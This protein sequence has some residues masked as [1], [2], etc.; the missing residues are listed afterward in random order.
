MTVKRSRRQ[1]VAWLAVVLLAA[2]GHALAGGEARESDPAALEDA[3]RKAL[4][5]GLYSLAEGY[6]RD[7]LEA[8]K[9][10][11]EKG[12]G[13]LGLAEALYGE[14]RYDEVE[15][16]I[17]A[18]RGWAATARQKDG[19][20][21][22]KAAVECVSKN[23]KGALRLLK[24]LLGPA[25]R[26]PWRRRAI[27]LGARCHAALGESDAAAKMFAAFVEEYTD[28]PETGRALLAW[29]GVLR[30][31]GKAEKAEKILAD[32]LQRFPERVE[33]CRARLWLAEMLQG[34]GRTAEARKMLEELSGKHGAPA[35]LRARAWMELAGLD[36]AER[37]EAAL[38]AADE[39][40]KLAPA[41]EL[42]D[43][44]RIL[45]VKMAIENG[46]VTNGVGLLREWVGANPKN[47]RAAD[48]QLETARL[49]FKK[50]F[51]EA[52]L[53][54]FQHYL[55]MFSGKAGEGAAWLGRGWCLLRLGRYSEAAEA[56]GRAWETADETAVKKEALI[57]KGDALFA[58]GKY[59]EARAQY[60]AFTRD[61]PGSDLAPQAL[62]QAAECLARTGKSAAAEKELRAVA[63]AFGD[64]EIAERCWIR[65]AELAEERGDWERARRVYTKVIDKYGES[66]ESARALHG[67]GMIYYRLGRFDAALQDFERV[68][69]EYAGGDY[70][71]QAFFMRGWCL[72]L[73]G[74]NRQALEVCREFV[75]KY[76]KSHWAPDV[77][78][79]LAEYHYN[80]R[81]AEEAEK[82]FLQVAD[83]YPQSRLA[84]ESLFWAGRAA[85]LQKEYLRAI[86]HF[87]R[88]A[89]E[90]PK[91][92][93]MA[94]ARFAQGDALSELG[95]F[96][97]AILAFE[98]VIKKY[99]D[100][101]LADL[102]WGRKGDCEFTLG[103]DDPSRYEEAV[104][105]YGV[106]LGENDVAAELRLQA[107][108]KI[109]RC[110]QKQGK[111][112]EA[113]RHY[114]NVV[115]GYLRLPREERRDGRLWFTRAAF[116][117]AA[118]REAQKD[119]RGAVN[120]YRRVVDAGVPAA[121]EAQ[122][123]IKEIRLAHWFLL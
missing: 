84:G 94:E 22:W 114:M 41:G 70:A 10:K 37:P 35:D 100:S 34:Q 44:A 58:G 43:R 51:T 30:G 63:D 77:L 2:W 111:T 93:R 4:A 86:E 81:N 16:L 1:I 25:A 72:Y 82:L 45:R 87:N 15:H 67:R 115:Y 59:E 14:G 57:K 105:A 118:M 75:A 12:R 78:F 48:V 117:A 9:H 38:R 103:R 109:G 27:F 31:A 122:K 61:F 20:R 53:E 54:E 21:Y 56:F 5:D 71:E 85:M 88:L 112:D 113:F 106:I 33:A 74:R 80:H 99:S 46:D 92:S 47:P 95:R 101:Y 73:M 121:V 49:L 91:C 102:A 39:A 76:P 23:Y 24:P 96:T 123:R 28:A 32:L 89:K 55:D 52:A 18:H 26:E 7:Y 11:E 62:F 108:Y 13:V 19:F 17:E 36:R 50:G 68:I 104:Q 119:W 83:S 8:V 65:I 40:E 90:H 60:L 107:E 69:K 42:R 110:R 79:W 66:S 97:E 6:F 64:N 120:I 98:E 29:A 116:D 3:G